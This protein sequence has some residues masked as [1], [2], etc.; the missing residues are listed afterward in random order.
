[1]SAIPATS[2]K[3]VVAGAYAAGKTTFIRSV[4]DSGFVSTETVASDDFGTKATT[5]AA[6]D[7]GVFSIDGGS[8][9]GRT[10]LLVFGLPGQ[11]RFEFMWRIL[12]QGALGYVLLV[13]AS[14]P[15]TWRE[16]VVIDATL[17]MGARLPR[18]VAVN[19]VNPQQ[20]LREIADILGIEPGVPIVICD[21]RDR[22]SAIG[23]LLTLFLEIAGRESLPAGE[24]DDVAITVTGGS[25]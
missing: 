25:K 10:E 9:G 4:A 20:D 1:M 22:A 18:V 7:F 21:P 8:G 3:I 6:M 2:I 23:V 5:T 11:A 17:A 24:G 14:K 16:T 19:R 15:E 12:A 13:D